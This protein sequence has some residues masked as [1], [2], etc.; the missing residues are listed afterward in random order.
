MPHRDE[1]AIER[2]R[3]V[4]LEE[5]PER[6]AERIREGAYAIAYAAGCQLTVRF[7]LRQGASI[8]NAEELAQAAWAKGWECLDQ[9]RNPDVLHCWV[10]SIA[11][12]MYRG[13]CR[14]P[15]QVPFE[16]SA[17]SSNLDLN[18]DI[19]RALEQLRDADRECFERRYIEGRGIREIAMQQHTSEG[20]VRI[21]LMRTRRR[22]RGLM[23][24]FT[25]EPEPV[26][27]HEV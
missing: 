12:N 15:K 21:R 20:A 6:R 27:E 17:S 11:L 8:D 9:L 4:E 10:N 3:I 23:T 22:M 14:R 26:A 16:D 19:E 13:A 18:L 24:L 7:L 25:N 1:A 5:S 2:S